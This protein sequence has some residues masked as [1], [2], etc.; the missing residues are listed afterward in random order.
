MNE[1]RPVVIHISDLFEKL[2]VAVELGA[3]NP[4]WIEDYFVMNLYGE[5]VVI[6]IKVDKFNLPPECSRR[7]TV[8]KYFGDHLDYIHHSDIIPM[9]PKPNGACVNEC[10]NCGITSVPQI[11]SFNVV[12]LD[13]NYLCRQFQNDVDQDIVHD[14]SHVV[15]KPNDSHIVVDHIR[16]TIPLV[17]ED[18]FDDVIGQQKIQHGEEV[19]YKDKYDCIPIKESVNNSAGSLTFF[20]NV[21]MIKGGAVFILGGKD[22]VGSND[23]LNEVADEVVSDDKVYE[24]AANDEYMDVDEVVSDD[25]VSEAAANDEDIDVVDVGQS[26]IAVS[27]HSFLMLMKN[28]NEF[29]VHF[30]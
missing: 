14:T 27:A 3:D 5:R 21:M 29:Y 18:N 23:I 19:P 9:T 1:N 26:E 15:A 4:Y 11:P 16:D 20:L 6:K 25:K 17:A 28:L 12:A 30:L 2:M 24:A 7:F 10:I 13:D 8:V 22:E